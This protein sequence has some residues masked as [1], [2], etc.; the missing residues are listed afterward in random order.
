M[1]GG[2]SS[3]CGGRG[4]G[5]SSGCAASGAGKGEIEWDP[6]NRQSMLQ[7]HE[8]LR[9]QLVWITER[10]EKVDQEIIEVVDRGARFYPAEGLQ[11]SRDEDVST[12][13]NQQS[14]SIHR[15]LTTSESRTSS[16]YPV[17]CRTNA[18]HD[19]GTCMICLE[20]LPADPRLVVNLCARQPQCLCLLH[21]S[22]Y[23]NPQQEMNDQLRRCMICRGPAK[24]ELV[25][26]A[27][28][29]RHVR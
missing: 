4:D 24:P 3:G 23:L 8:D 17:A 10:T 14:G 21:R 13:D 6:S 1:P 16:D 29:A 5:S 15:V 28:Q 7:A 25:R 19:M 27:V 18:T 22:C 2:A 20:Q 12:P 9:L 26:Q 11:E